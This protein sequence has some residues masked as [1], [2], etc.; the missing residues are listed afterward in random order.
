MSRG[1]PAAEGIERRLRRSGSR[2]GRAARAPTTARSAGRG[3]QSRPAALGVVG[4]LRWTWRQLTS[5]RVALLLLMLLAVAAVPGSVLPQRPQDPARV[6]EYLADHPDLGPWLDRVGAFDVYASVWFSAIYLLLFV[7]LVGCIVPRTPRAPRRA[8]CP[9][10]PHA[11]ALRPLPGAC[12]PHDDVVPG[13]RSP[14]RRPSAL[15][16][17]EVAAAVPGRRPARGRRH[18][19]RGRARLP[20][21]ERQPR[22]PPRPRRPADLG[23][24]RPVPALPRAGDRRSRAAGSPTP[25]STTTRSRA[26]P[27]STRRASCRSR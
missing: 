27:A 6:A 4:W 10:A 3:C 5:M 19:R 8:A 15:R 12:R 18:D 24:D 23:R 26:A 11:A 17:R 9:S 13:R 1:A 21:G 25:S 7:S 16:G 2:P 14:P 22:L 20:A